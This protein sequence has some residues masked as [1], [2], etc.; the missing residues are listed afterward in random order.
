MLL[1][2]LIKQGCKLK[3]LLPRWKLTNKLA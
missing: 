2:T 1:K 3:Y